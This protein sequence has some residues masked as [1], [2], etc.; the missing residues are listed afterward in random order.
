MA[1]RGC[2]F[3]VFANW[4][5]S[6]KDAEGRVLCRVCGGTVPKPRRTICS[7]SCQDAISLM[8][9]LAS[10]AERLVFAR[11]KGVSAKCGLNTEALIERATLERLAP[12]WTRQVSRVVGARDKAITALLEQWG[13]HHYRTR[14][15]DID[16]ILAVED[17]GLN[18]LGN[19]ATLCIPCHKEKSAAQTTRRA[20]ARRHRAKEG[21]KARALR[22]ARE[23]QFQRSKP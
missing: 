23:A 18:V 20:N 4:D 17:G 13:I 12:G 2:D 16:H 9:G 11:D 6:R 21:P 10:T 5:G 22:E 15:W 8:A 19:L 14:L 3:S 7:A 1:A